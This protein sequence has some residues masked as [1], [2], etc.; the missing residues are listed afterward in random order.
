MM[1]YW[2]CVPA[3]RV[4]ELGQGPERCNWLKADVKTDIFGKLLLEAG[5][6]EDTI[7]EWSV[8]PR[9]ALPEGGEGLLQH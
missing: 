2:S 6:K 3:A 9:V 8:D 5:I 1:T 7:K 4:L